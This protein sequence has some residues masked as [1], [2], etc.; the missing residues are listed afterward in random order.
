[1]A[2]VGRVEPLAD[3]TVVLSAADS[4]R[5][6]GARGHRPLCGDQYRRTTSNSWAQ[7]AFN[8]LIAVLI[9]EMFLAVETLKNIGGRATFTIEMM[10]EVFPGL[11]L[12][13]RIDLN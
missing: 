13:A 10:I 9:P 2:P 4:S 7:P 3:A 11:P 5:P 1:M 8:R 12:K 6:E